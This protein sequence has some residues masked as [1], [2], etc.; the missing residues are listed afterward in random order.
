MIKKVKKPKT[1][2]D[3]RKSPDEDYEVYYGSFKMFYRKNAR[4]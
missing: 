3:F 1:L 2:P 4:L